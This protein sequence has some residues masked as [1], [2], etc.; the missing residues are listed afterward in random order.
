MTPERTRDLRSP[1][2]L[3]GPVL[4]QM[5]LIFL[6]SSIPNLSRLPGGMSD[7]SGHSIGYA[8]LGGL[9]LRALARGR[10]REVTWLRG[11][12]AVMLAGAYGASDE[13]H[14]SFVA[15]RSA[16]RYDVAADFAGA[17]FGVALAWLAR[18]ARRWGILDSSS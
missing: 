4:L 9:L 10:L 3:W 13:F 1:A 16:D 5:V 2:W 18:A 14:Q 15:G 6:A 12:V 11:L 17:A 8:L 7:K